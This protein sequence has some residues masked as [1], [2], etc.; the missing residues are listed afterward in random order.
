VRRAWERRHRD[1]RKSDLRDDRVG[2]SPHLGRNRDEDA[3]NVTPPGPQRPSPGPE[4][5]AW[6]ALSTLTFLWHGQSRPRV[7]RCCT[8]REEVRSSRHL[9][10]DARP[11]SRIR[12]PPVP[13][14]R[15]SLH[16]FRTPA[17]LATAT[18]CP[19]RGERGG[20]LPGDSLRVPRPS[21]P[22]M[23]MG[24]KLAYILSFRPINIGATAWGSPSLPGDSQR[25]AFA[26][27]TG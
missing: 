10:D 4:S 9:R 6:D 27:M 23:L 26:E 7:G 15:G 2:E 17:P 20:C 21:R 1:V 18:A 22:P 24:R 25:S 14:P 16:T 19:G 5:R 3:G 8:T 13:L 12:E 11:P